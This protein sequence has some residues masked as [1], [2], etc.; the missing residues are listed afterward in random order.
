[1]VDAEHNLSMMTQLPTVHAHVLDFDRRNQ[2]PFR[3]PHPDPYPRCV[4]RRGGIEQAGDG[5][6]RRR[7]QFRTMLY[8]IAAAAPPPD[9][10]E[11]DAA[12]DGRTR[13]DAGEGQGGLREGGETRE[14]G[15]RRDG[16]TGVYYSV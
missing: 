12:T 8:Y 6:A 16:E 9:D 11:R 2:F 14:G 10:D 1:M 7:S 3:K 4:A 13:S 15:R 5:A